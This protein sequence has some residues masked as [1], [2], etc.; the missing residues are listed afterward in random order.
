MN[1]GGYW[2][3]DDDD[4]RTRLHNNFIVNG[5]KKCKKKRLIY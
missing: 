3:M 2:M 5:A 1:D 4:G